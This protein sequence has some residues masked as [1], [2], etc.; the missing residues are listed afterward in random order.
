MTV[1]VRSIVHPVVGFGSSLA[2][3]PVKRAGECDGVGVDGAKERAAR[4]VWPSASR[5]PVPEGLRTDPNQTRE[6]LLCCQE[7]RADVLDISWR[8]LDFRAPAIGGRKRLFDM[9]ER[10]SE[11]IDRP[12]EAVPP[13]PKLANERV[14][15]HGTTAVQFQC[16]NS[17][18]DVIPVSHPNGSVTPGQRGQ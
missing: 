13:V 15:R 2:R 16:R 14:A 1:Q 17:A 11:R 7:L 5:L 6:I 4:A 10:I 18:A 9:H 3:V 12:A 8:E